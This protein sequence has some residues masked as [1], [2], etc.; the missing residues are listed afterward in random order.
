MNGHAILQ[1]GAR[2]SRYIDYVRCR[3]VK[4]TTNRGNISL[5]DENMGQESADRVD[6][7]HCLALK[8]DFFDTLF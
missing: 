8:S 5:P 7:T 1:I 2:K 4:M 3:I 6:G